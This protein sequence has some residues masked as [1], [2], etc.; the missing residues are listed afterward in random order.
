M[1]VGETYDVELPP[2]AGEYELVIDTWFY[3]A[4]PKSSRTMRVPVVVR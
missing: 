1:G 3:P 2:G 4:T